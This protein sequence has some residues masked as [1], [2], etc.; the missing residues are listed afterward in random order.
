LS[1]W[2]E[3]AR[4]DW[5]NNRSAGYLADLFSTALVE[6]KKDDLPFLSRE[7]LDLGDKIP[8][9]LQRLALNVL[10]DKAEVV[11]NA[12]FDLS[13]KVEKEAVSRYVSRLRKRVVE[14][15]GNAFAWHDLSY[16]YNLL[17]EQ[18]KAERAMLVALRVSSSHRVIARSASRFYMHQSDPE[19]ASKVLRRAQGFSKDPWLLAAHVAVAQASGEESGQLTVAR[20]LYEQ[21]TNRLQSSELGMA[22]A[23]QEMLLGRNKKAKIIAREASFLPTEN[24]LAQG[25]WLASKLHAD[26]VQKDV[27][28]SASLAFEAR[29]WEAYYKGAWAESAKYAIE[30]LSY[31]PFSVEPAIHG[32][33]IAAT[34]LRDF[35]MC[36]DIANFGLI[37]NPDSWGLKN[38][39][40]VALASLDKVDDALEEFARLGMPNEDAANYVVWLATNGLLF[41]RQ[42][43]IEDARASY[44]KSSDMIEK[45]KDRTA[46]LVSTFFQS[47]EEA[48][49]GNMEKAVALVNKAGLKFGGIR[50]DKAMASIFEFDVL[51]ASGE[52]LQQRIEQLRALQ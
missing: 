1:G 3:Q 44:E 50:A 49:L 12:K 4:A 35:H 5:L 52:E 32:S 38:N 48:R 31:E 19:S 29:S 11:S 51:N 16:M 37:S 45:R 21:L 13:V 14:F 46:A 15:P 28:A 39:K 24:A 17:G 27:V 30:W 41:Y 18:W 8:K 34:Y 47:A 23:T 9:G 2:Y 33:F 42:G 10:H 7:I 26:I 22:L 25:V 20:R 36:L 6:D 43:L 40:V